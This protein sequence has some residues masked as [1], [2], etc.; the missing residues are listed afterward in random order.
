MTLYQLTLFSI[1]DKYDNLIEHVWELYEQLYF[2]T[3][4]L[5]YITKISNNYKDLIFKL[6]KL[7]NVDKALDVTTVSKVLK[8]AIVKQKKT[9][10]ALLILQKKIDR[11]NRDN[12]IFKHINAFTDLETILLN[13]NNRNYIKILHRLNTNITIYPY[14]RESTFQRIQDD[15]EILKSNSFAESYINITKELIDVELQIKND[16]G[17]YLLSINSIDPILDKNFFQAT[18]MQRNELEAIKDKIKNM[19]IKLFTILGTVILFIIFIVIKMRKS[20]SKPATIILRTMEKMSSGDLTEKAEYNFDNEMGHICLNINSAIDTLKTLILNIKTSSEQSGIMGTIINDI[21]TE[22]ST[23]MTEISANLNMITTQMSNLVVEI[24][25]SNH[26]SNLISKKAEE[27]NNLVS[28]QS[29]ALEESTAAIEEMI[30][31][32]QNVSNIATEKGRIADSL[33]ELTKVGGEKIESTSDLI[34]EVSILTSEILEVI[35]VINEIASQTN[36]LAMNAAIEAAHAGD[37]GKGFSVVADEI[38]KLAEST[39]DNSTKINESLN[40]IVKKIEDALMV[41]NDSNKAFESVNIEVIDLTNSLHEIASFMTE[42]STGS[43]E[44]LGAASALAE[45]TGDIRD[46]AGTIRN[47]T[48]EISDALTKMDSL[49]SEINSGIKEVSLAGEEIAGST[50]TLSV[51]SSKNMDNAKNL[52][53]EADKFRI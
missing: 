7:N 20:I 17:K 3:G 48:V 18:N 23:A 40:I 29:S 13:N 26:S 25:N 28:D 44:V 47:E 33:T 16:M 31:S 53:N 5:T 8:D 49:V 51:E 4:N 6:E 38:R 52:N 42:M 41:S 21:S 22:T 36:L 27:F 24:S 43:K 14:E 50:E 39:G 9:F 10:D 15:I 45:I 32:I 2:N 30:A 1:R 19:M 46:G 34:K 12:L 37:A 11:D 35:N